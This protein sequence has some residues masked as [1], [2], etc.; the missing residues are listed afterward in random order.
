[1]KSGKVFTMT[2]AATSEA[3]G[4]FQR[5]VETTCA[6]LNI[7]PA[8]C[9]DL[10]LTIGEVCA[11]IIAH[12]YDGINS[13][14]ISLTLGLHAKKVVVTIADFGRPLDPILEI[15]NHIGETIQDLPLGGFGLGLWFRTMENIRYEVTHA[16]NYLTFMKKLVTSP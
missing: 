6:S 1:M 11:H 2:V 8:I 3:V 12:G 9:A 13:G 10:K 15:I 14:S 4:Q 16:G 5:F 7:Q